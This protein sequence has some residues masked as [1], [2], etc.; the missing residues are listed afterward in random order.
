M[1]KISVSLEDGLLESIRADADEGNVSSWLADAAQRKL[2]SRALHDY[3][4]DVEAASG[5]LTDVELEQGHAWLSSAT[6][7]S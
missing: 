3:A 2:R 6:P 4:D 1:A 5:P 7:R